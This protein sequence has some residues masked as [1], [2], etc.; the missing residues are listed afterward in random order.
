MYF[1]N[2][3]LRSS[4]MNDEERE[5]GMTFTPFDNNTIFSTSPLPQQQ[6]R[7]PPQQQLALSP[8]SYQHKNILEEN[9]IPVTESS[10]FISSG[11][12]TTLK[13]SSTLPVAGGILG[14]SVKT[15]CGDT[16][17]QHM[18]YEN[19]IEQLTEHEEKE[20]QQSKQTS[21]HSFNLSSSS[22]NRQI[23]S[24]PTSDTI[25]PTNTTQQITP[26][27][28]SSLSTSSLPLLSS[29]LSPS[30]NTDDKMQLRI[31][32]IA[33]N[34]AKSRVETQ[35]KLCV[36]LVTNQGTKVPHWSFIRIPESLLARSK[37]RKAQQK[38]LTGKG[39]FSTGNE[40][41]D[42]SKILDLSATV[43]CVSEPNKKLK[44]C[45]GC[46]RRERKRAE[47]KKDSHLT[48]A[49]LSA[50]MSDDSFEQE[51]K[52]ILLFNC[53]PF[54][55]FTSG[56]AILPTRIT[57]YC[58]HHNER[59]G[60]RYIIQFMLRD[61]IGNIVATGETPSIMITDDHKSSKQS[62]PPLPPTSLSFPTTINNNDNFI[63]TKQ[64]RR[65]TNYAPATPA[66]SKRGSTCTTIGG[67]TGY[68]NSN[69]TNEE[70]SP[71]STSS[72]QSPQRYQSSMIFQ[73]HNHMNDRQ[74]QKFSEEYTN[75]LPTPAEEQISPVFGKTESETNNS[76]TSSWYISDRPAL[77]TNSSL[78]SLPIL[79]ENNDN[80]LTTTTSTTNLQIA[81][82]TA[83]MLHKNEQQQ[84]F[85]NQDNNNNNNNVSSMIP[86]S[87]YPYSI[88]TNTTNNFSSRNNSINFTSTSSTS[89]S[90]S[91]NTSTT[92]TTPSP[93]MVYNHNNNST[94][95]QNS[96]NLISLS[97]TPTPTPH[98]ERLV[99][100]QGPVHGSIEI[101][102]LGSN[103]IEGLTCLFGDR[104]AHTVYW[105]PSTLVCIL[106]ASTHPGTVTVSFKEHPIV[107]TRQQA[108]LFTYYDT[109]DHTLMELALQV[110]GLKMNGT[111]QEA[112]HIAMGI[113]QGGKQ[114]QQNTNLSSISSPS[115]MR[116]TNKDNVTTHC[117]TNVEQYVAN[118]LEA[119]DVDDISL[120]NLQGHTLLHLAV[121]C[122][123]KRLALLLLTKD[124]SNIVGV[125][126]RNGMSPLDMAFLKNDKVMIEMLLQDSSNRHTK[127]CLSKS[128][129]PQ[130]RTTE[131]QHMTIV[132]SPSGEI[133]K[134]LPEEHYQQEQQIFSSLFTKSEQQQQQQEQQEQN[135]K[136][137]LASNLLCSMEKNR[138][139]FAER[140]YHDLFW[141]PI[142]LNNM[143]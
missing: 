68:D 98:I 131:Q 38:K 3:S 91:L 124:S 18:Y 27:P 31:L 1:S 123:Y 138:S 7:P 80:N 106:P 61:S 99:P 129:F 87:S 127:S 63:V 46:V 24:Y 19:T 76:D 79:N 92:N 90:P 56:D 26:L 52:R 141:L 100:G 109:N 71:S 70:L 104:P 73:L 116:S 85:I 4:F 142:S 94:H 113:V 96:N 45:T 101:T 140:K 15:G 107:I 51:R 86:T 23:S 54:M 10:P 111:L 128:P 120:M 133:Q 33:E 62:I 105:S 117:I 136:K 119:V 30:S 69:K 121:L 139:G 14:S 12:V 16:S 55:E 65:R 74:Q 32:G 34:G 64:K 134:Q 75:L 37:L 47:R 125:Q 39:I 132:S 97:T 115:V 41:P 57:C 11:T 95:N 53:E 48:E 77:P 21:L 143:K 2:G 13:H 112:K 6:Q 118:A 40:G 89:T 108:S 17:A 35:I 5:V 93:I 82:T 84:T 83:T 29:P 9:F 137:M 43:I 36:Q 67:R 58:R 42:R 88:T 59:S 49:A 103:F 44:M 126:D 135:V 122:G 130:N 60:F 78:S 20:Q 25:I 114:K 28:P 72:L 50:T 66:S 81:A 110:V 22:S 8:M 102:I